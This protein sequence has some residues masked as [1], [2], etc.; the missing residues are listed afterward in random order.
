M[1][2]SHYV[3]SLLPLESII[4]EAIDNLGIESKKLKFVLCSTIYED[5]NGAMVVA[6]SPSM[7]P[8]SKHTAVKYHW[9]G[10]TL[11]RNL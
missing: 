8:T 2:L 5:K 10:S 7:T 9:L 4:N 1:A 11:E 6:R 3:G